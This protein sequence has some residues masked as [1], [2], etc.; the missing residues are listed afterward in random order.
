MKS[1]G[2]FIVLVQEPWHYAGGVRGLR[3]AGLHV[4]ETSNGQIPR[5]CIVVSSNISIWPLP[6]QSN[7]DIMAVKIVLGRHRL[8]VGSVY[9]PWDREI[10]EQHIRQ[11]A[12][13][14]CMYVCMFV[15]E[16]VY[17]IG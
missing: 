5:A 3:G 4:P 15:E 8:T 1:T 12:E 10:P 14:A 7:R 16:V 13:R 6:R 17:S 11:L 2:S 9:M